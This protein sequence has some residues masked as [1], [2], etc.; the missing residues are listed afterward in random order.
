MIVEDTLVH[1]PKQSVVTGASYT[2]I[3]RPHVCGIRAVACRFTRSLAEWARLPAL[4]Y[5]AL[6]EATAI[7]TLLH[8][9]ESFEPDRPIA[10]MRVLSDAWLRGHGIARPRTSGMNGAFDVRPS[11]S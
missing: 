11:A 2:T 8:H 5:A 7:V 6:W 3:N 4:P 1:S 10:D 9:R